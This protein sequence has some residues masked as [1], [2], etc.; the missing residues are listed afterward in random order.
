MIQRLVRITSSGSKN[1]F[2]LHTSCIFVECTSSNSVYR[3]SWKFWNLQQTFSKGRIC[4]WK[5]HCWNYRNFK[6]TAL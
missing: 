3:L 6:T 4:E 2:I 1:V 5:M